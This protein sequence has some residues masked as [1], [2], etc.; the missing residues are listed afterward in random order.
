M[1]LK[2]SGFE[3]GQEVEHK[4]SKYTGKIQKIIDDVVTVKVGDEGALVDVKLEEFQAGNVSCL[5][6]VAK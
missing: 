3:I 6:Q 5:Q 2:A 1:L 4:Q